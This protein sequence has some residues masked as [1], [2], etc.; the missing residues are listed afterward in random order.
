MTS[1]FWVILSKKVKF[2]LISTNWG[3]IINT[4]Q[5]KKQILNIFF[6]FLWHIMEREDNFIHSMKN[7]LNAMKENHYTHDIRLWRRLMI[8]QAGDSLIF[9]LHMNNTK[10]C[11][12]SF[13]IFTNFC[14]VW[15]G[16]LK[17]LICCFA[18][19]ISTCYWV[20]L[21]FFGIFI[22][23]YWPLLA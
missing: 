15:L 8:N 13:L 10:I 11:A 2:V 7:G 18:I 6:T 22:H 4:A 3:W 5:D 23:Y 9:N 1:P 19:T 20:L 12:F 21:R 14:L 17:T 16:K